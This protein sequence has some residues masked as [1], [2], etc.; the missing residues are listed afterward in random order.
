MSKA[1]NYC[2]ECKN[3]WQKINGSGGF[4]VRGFI[5]YTKDSKTL[6]C[7]ECRYPERYKEGNDDD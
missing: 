3:M 7:P 6:I 5:P 4:R 2:P 1:W